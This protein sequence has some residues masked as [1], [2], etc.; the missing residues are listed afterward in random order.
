MQPLQVSE[1]RPYPALIF[2]AVP[3]EQTPGVSKSKTRWCMVDTHDGLGE[4]VQS[5]VSTDDALLCLDFQEQGSLLVIHLHPNDKIYIVD[6]QTLGAEV[7]ELRHGF[8]PAQLHSSTTCLE[9]APDPR[10][11]SLLDIGQLPSLRGLL[12]SPSIHKVVFDSKKTAPALDAAFAVTLRG[13]QD[14]QVI[15]ITGRPLPASLYFHRKDIGRRIDS[16][17]LRCCL[18]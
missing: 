4:L 9:I 14:V 18:E 7:L 16:R 17:S 3:G 6:L 15:E 13:L 5:I 11:Q 10:G 2:R 1:N 8:N 12:E